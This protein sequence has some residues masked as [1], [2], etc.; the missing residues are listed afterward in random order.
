M[1]EL[2]KFITENDL[3]NFGVTIAK[4]ALNAFRHRFMKHS[5]FIHNNVSAL[6]L[7]RESYHGGRTETFRMG[8]IKVKPVYIMD[9]NSMYPS[10]MQEN[11]YPTRLIKVIDDPTP[12]EFKRMRSRF[13]CIARLK[14]KTDFPCVPVD[15]GRRLIFPVGEFI[16]TLCSP[17]IELIEK[18]GE[19]K[20]VYQVALYQGDH[21]FSKYVEYFYQKR[22]EAKRS[23]DKVKELLYKMVLN[24]LYG[25]F[26]QRGYN[27]KVIGDCSPE[28]IRD[29]VI[30]HSTSNTW[31]KLKYI[32]G[33]I[34]ERQ[35]EREPYNTFPAI[36]SFVTSYA[37]VAL[38]KYILLAGQDN[39]FYCDTDS[40]FLSPEGYQRVKAFVSDG[41]LGCLRLEKRA[42]SLVI[43]GLKDYILNTKETH[44]G[45]P[46]KAQ[47]VKENTWEVTVWP[48]LKT[49]LKRGNVSTYANEVITKTLWRN[50]QKGFVLSSGQVVPYI[51]RVECNT[52]ELIPYEE[53]PYAEMAPSIPV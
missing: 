5:I 46:A 30:F 28:E 51:L 16:T 52:N 48:H 15:L 21:I 23:G 26:A 31:T 12:E 29:E 1:L 42:L 40:L 34:L 20:E 3:G 33:S 17:E 49:F 43:F 9:I 37:R 13:L 8:E 4:Q 53:T 22:V 32:G 35:E 36:S 41:A 14:V 50:Y 6:E 39:V 24:S 38:Y 27:W 10:V 11:L 2:M 25:K 19:I 47:K 18:Y 44:K 7:E 45:I